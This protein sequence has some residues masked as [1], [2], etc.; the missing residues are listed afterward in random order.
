MAPPTGLTRCGSMAISRCHARTT[1]ANASL[2]STASMSP[3]VRPASF[4]A[5]RVPGMGALSIMIGSS[6]TTVI[7]RMRA[8][9]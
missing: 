2:I 4:S 8:R 6:P 1:G 7:R 3:S 5:L 9:G